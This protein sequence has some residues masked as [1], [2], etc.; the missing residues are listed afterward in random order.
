MT[1]RQ[2]EALLNA[3]KKLV[4]AIRYGKHGIDGEIAIDQRCDQV[5]YIIKNIE[6]GA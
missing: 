6:K 1:K 4:F 2:S 5:E 3:V